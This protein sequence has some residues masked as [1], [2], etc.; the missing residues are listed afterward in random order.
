MEKIYY[1]NGVKADGL[2]EHM[3]FG[4]VGIDYVDGKAVRFFYMEGGEN[5]APIGTVPSGIYDVANNLYQFKDKL[6]A[7]D[8]WNIKDIKC[9]LNESKPS[10][11]LTRGEKALN[12]LR[13]VKNSAPDFNLEFITHEGYFIKEHKD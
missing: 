7:K 8:E 9:F 3:N 13:F 6:I 2:H 12:V 11:M 5:N 1:N 4:R 10:F